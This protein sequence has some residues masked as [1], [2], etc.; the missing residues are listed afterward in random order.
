MPYLHA[1]GVDRGARRLF[2]PAKRRPQ[3]VELAPV[4]C[5]A[6]MMRPHGPVAAVVVLDR[7]EE[8]EPAGRVHLH[9][10]PQALRRVRLRQL[11]GGLRNTHTHTVRHTHTDRERDIQ[12]YTDRQT[13]THTHTHTERGTERDKTHT[14]THIHTQAHRH[15][16][17]HTDIQPDKQR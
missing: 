16:Q 9:L 6:V 4:G 15:T 12:R 2:L 1:G 3:V 10:R 8:L 5:G 14:H 13:D 17:T 7:P 11:R